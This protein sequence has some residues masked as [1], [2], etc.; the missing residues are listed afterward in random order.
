MRRIG[1]DNKA[2]HALNFL[3]WRAK[4]ERSGPL[5]EEVEDAASEIQQDVSKSGVTGGIL[6][7]H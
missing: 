2:L 4:G 5:K 7:L 3:I 6:R 1:W